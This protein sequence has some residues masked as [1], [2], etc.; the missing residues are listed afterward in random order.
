MDRNEARQAGSRVRAAVFDLGG[1]VIEIFMDR[2]VRAWA[3]ATGLEPE[4]IRGR[5][6]DLPTGQ[7][8]RTAY[9]RFERGEI[10]AETFRRGVCERLGRRMSRE[11]FDR[12]WNALLG[13]PLEG[14]EALLESLAQ[15]LRLVLLTNTNCV[16][17]ASWRRTCRKVLAPLERV[18]VSYEIGHRKPE[19]ECF[20]VVLEYLGLA[21]EEVAYFDDLEENVR[22]AAGL[23]MIAR[24][25]DGASTSRAWWRTS[26]R[27]MCGCRMANP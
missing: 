3:E 5:L 2:T 10:D 15:R 1:V 8:G 4:A 7:A 23:G 13:G 27:E 18:F 21:P 20:S 17:A 25:V 19:P 11:A 22:A 24:V 14:A 6:E 12:G 9:H 16:H 26:W